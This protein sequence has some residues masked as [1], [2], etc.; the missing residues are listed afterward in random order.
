MRT[1]LIARLAYQ[2]KHFE[3][4]FQSAVNEFELSAEE[5]FNLRRLLKI[6]APAAERTREM[7]MRES[8]VQAAAYYGNIAAK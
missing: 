1:Q 3:A 5:R 8:L 7:L 4:F 2:I 6:Q